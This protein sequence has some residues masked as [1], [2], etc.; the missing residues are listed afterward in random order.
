MLAASSRFWVDR[1]FMF[2]PPIP[3]VRCN[4]VAPNAKQKGGS[5][6]SLIGDGLRQLLGLR[7]RLAV[8]STFKLTPV[9]AVS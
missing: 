1:L 5:Q 2:G 9:D 6:V 8:R 4:T 3:Y 7:K